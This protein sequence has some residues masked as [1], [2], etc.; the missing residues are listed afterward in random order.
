VETTVPTDAAADVDPEGAH[1]ANRVPHVGGSEPPGKIE[2]LGRHGLADLGAHRPV[3]HAPGPAQLLDR[4]PG[5]A[6]VQEDGVGVS[7]S[8][9]SSS[10]S[11]ST[12]WTT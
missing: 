3:V 2:R 8:T 4:R 7:S 10:E 6:G 9:A 5:S 11:P 12:T 1:G